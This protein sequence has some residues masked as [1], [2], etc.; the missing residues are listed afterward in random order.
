M[1]KNRMIRRGRYSPETQVEVDKDTKRFS[2]KAFRSALHRLQTLE[3]KIYIDNI[4]YVQSRNMPQL[5]DILGELSIK[6]S[7]MTYMYWEVSSFDEFY[8]DVI[9]T[10]LEGLSDIERSFEEEVIIAIDDG[11]ADLDGVPDS[12]LQ[13]LIETEIQ[14]LIGN[15]IDLVETGIEEIK[16][17]KP[18][19]DYKP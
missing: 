18:G 6:M 10:I 19:I 16:A 3:S 1:S 11:L 7:D 8:D 4:S 12:P 15:A 14:P 9:F 17:L 2:L 5:F 13:D